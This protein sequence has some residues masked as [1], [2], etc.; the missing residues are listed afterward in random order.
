MLEILEF[1]RVEPAAAIAAAGVLGL[2][3]GSFLNVVILRLPARL[4]Y[5]WRLDALEVLQGEGSGD[6]AIVASAAAAGTPGTQAAPPGLVMQRSHCPKCGALIRAWDNI[7]LL[8]YLVLGGK[9]RACKTPISKQYPLVEALTGIATALCVWRFGVGFEALMAMG[10]TWTMIALAGID[11]RTQLLPDLMTLPLLWVGLL[12]SLLPLWATPTQAILG[13]AI[14]YL[15]LWS[16]YWGFKLL[17]GKEGM[18]YGDFKLLAALGACL[19]VAAIL[20]IILLSSIVGA[21]LGAALLG[22]RGRDSQ[23]PMPFGPFLAAAGWVYLLFWPNIK[24]W[25]PLF[26]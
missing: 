18:G 13:G 9:C 24:P 3:I 19:G 2:L 14:G 22:F 17:T 1:L 6:A 7:P 10:F 8:S 12:L 4:E 21:V 5:R 16:V 11:F 25:I 23:Q 20:P 26:S 15:S